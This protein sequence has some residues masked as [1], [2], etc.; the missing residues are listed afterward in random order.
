M[1]QQRVGR[2]DVQRGLPPLIARVQIGT[3]FGEQ[4]ENF[5]L[6][7]ESGMMDSAVAVLVLKEPIAVGFPCSCRSTSISVLA[8]CSS[9]ARVISTW[10]F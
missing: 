4:F 10:P 8:L 6:I 1:D 9:K 5:Y 2:T 3:R 7:A